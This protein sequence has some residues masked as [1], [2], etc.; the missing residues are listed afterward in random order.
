MLRNDTILYLLVDKFTAFFFI[1]HTRVELDVYIGNNIARHPSFSTSPMSSV[2]GG[3]AMEVLNAGR[4]LRRLDAVCIP[5]TTTSS[6]ATKMSRCSIN[7]FR[8]GGPDHHTVQRRVAAHSDGV[9]SSTTSPSQS[10]VHRMSRD[11][12]CR[13]RHVHPRNFLEPGRP[14]LPKAVPDS[15]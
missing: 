5:V 7:F 13:H 12:M 15:G 2:V 8:I 9:V 11:L 10:P 3:L 14:P 4:S 6:S 1:H